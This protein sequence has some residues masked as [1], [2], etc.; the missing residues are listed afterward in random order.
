MSAFT[1]NANADK[2]YAST[3]P[4]MRFAIKVLDEGYTKIANSHSAIVYCYDNLL[5]VKL[6]A[7]NYQP[8]IQLLHEWIELF[9]SNRSRGG[10]IPTLAQLSG[11]RSYQEAQANEPAGLV[12]TAGALR[13]RLPFCTGRVSRFVMGDGR[14]IWGSCPSLYAFGQGFR[15]TRLC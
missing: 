10:L 2:I 5:P 6:K 15:A 13:S 7:R 4:S 14:W 12:H 3:N 1:E 11:R 9:F 8:A